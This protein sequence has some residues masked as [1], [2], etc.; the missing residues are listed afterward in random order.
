MKIT[1]EIKN[2]KD[3]E[4][5][6]PLLERLRI[7]II[8]SVIIQND[9]KEELLA[10]D[11]VSNTTNDFFESAGLFENRIIDASTLRKRAWKLDK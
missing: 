5:L 11:N 10:E 9:A 6:K 4:L 7:K 2:L 1:L 8:D 3:W